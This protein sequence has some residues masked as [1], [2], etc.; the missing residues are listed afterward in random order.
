MQEAEYIISTLIE[1]GVLMATTDNVYRINKRH[2]LLTK[3]Y[4]G[5]VAE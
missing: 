4:Y 3:D 1:H 5:L 2:G